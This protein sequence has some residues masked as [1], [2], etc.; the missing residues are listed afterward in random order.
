MLLVAGTEDMTVNLTI[1]FDENNL[2]AKI[3]AYRK[4]KHITQAE[5]ARIMGVKHVTLRAWE[6]GKAKPPY[7]IWRQYKYLFDK[8]IDIL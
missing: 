6:Q 1:H 2:A 4:K 5:L 7:H 3:K 8:S